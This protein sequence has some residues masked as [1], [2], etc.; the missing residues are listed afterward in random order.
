MLNNMENKT[1]DFNNF[2]EID[3]DSTK[4][5]FCPDGVKKGSTLS[6]RSRIDTLL[7]E[8]GIK[9]AD[10]YNILGWCK[11]YASIVHNGKLIPPTWQR[12][13]LAKQLGVDTSVIWGGKND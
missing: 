4:T 5:F 12:V 11:S 9:W 2:S 6:V 8:R 3:K 10:V 13:A 1:S 7:L